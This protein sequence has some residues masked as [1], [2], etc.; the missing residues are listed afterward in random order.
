MKRKKMDAL[1]SQLQEMHEK[2]RKELEAEKMA[3]EKEKATIES[4]KAMMENAKVEPS[5]IIE[6]NVG[7]EAIIQCRR[8]TLCLA[9]D[10]MFTYMFSGRW[11]DSI[12]RDD[13]GRVFFDHDPELIRLIINHL[14]IKQ[15]E[16][17]EQPVGPPKIPKGKKRELICLL[18]Y[19]GLFSFFFGDSGD[20]KVANLEFAHVNSTLL[21]TV[22]HDSTE[23]KLQYNG[24]GH[25]FAALGPPLRSQVVSCWKIVI[26]ALPNN[27]GAFCW[28]YLGIIGGLTCVSETSY[29]H[30][31]SHGWVTHSQVY[32]SGRSHK[33]MV[34]WT[35]F[36]NGEEL[37]FY[38][39]NSKLSMY[40][41]R[42]NKTFHMGVQG[43]ENA[44]IHFNFNANQTQ[45]TVSALNEEEQ[46]RM[47]TLM[48]EE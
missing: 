37:H 4:E 46:H 17:P 8:Q 14:R 31:S 35:G 29:G 30:A 28:L 15:I 42:K 48:D 24:G 27:N 18:R 33:H 3:L 25:S 20:F 6:I 47:V 10:T 1:W 11:K 43:L 7:G 23:L 2:E 40:S 32:C 26:D 19:F 45:L 9:P 13:K 16:N 39:G 21:R 34:G 12:P 22:K 44:F 38:Y 36:E 41:V 5:D